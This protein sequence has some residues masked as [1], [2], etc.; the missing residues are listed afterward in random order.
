MLINAQA[1]DDSPT[2]KKTLT[3]GE[4]LGLC[5]EFLMAG[6]ATISLSLAYTSYLL[7]LNPDKQDLLYEAID[8][9]Y[10]ENEV[11]NCW[12]IYYIL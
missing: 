8:N 3:D 9:Y 4:I 2:N 5:F 6:Y 7:A 10:Q 1:E 11:R 12:S